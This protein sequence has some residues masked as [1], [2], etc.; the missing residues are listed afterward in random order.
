MPRVQLPI[1]YIDNVST[2][3]HGAVSRPY[4]I[5][6]IPEP[7]ETDVP[8]TTAI[9]I[10]VV[11]TSTNGLRP[12]T[13]V[14][15]TTV[16]EGT[17]AAFTQ[18]IGFDSTYTTSVFVTSSSPGA[19]NIDTHKI[20]L[21]RTTPFLSNEIVTVNVQATSADFKALNTTY[22][23][24][25]VDL[26]TPTIVNAYTSGLTTLIV[27]FSEPIDM[28]G[29]SRSV[30][31]VR[32]LSGRVSFTAPDFIEVGDG[33]FTADSVNDYIC[34]TGASNAINNVYR[35][36]EAL[37]SS[38]EIVTYETD[39]ASEE[40]SLDV[41]AWVGPFK[42]EPVMDTELLFPAFTP[43]IVAAEMIDAQTVKLT[44]EQELTPKHAYRIVATNVN[45]AAFIPNTTHGTSYVFTTEPL[46]FV[47]NR[48]FRLWENFI[49]A[50][51]KRQDTSGD[52]QRFV[53]CFDEVTQLLLNDIDNLQFLQDVDLMPEAALDVA[54]ANLANPYT[55]VTNTL[56]KRKTI[57]SLVKEYKDGGVDRGITDAVKFFL[58]LDVTI[59]SF[60]LLDGWILGVSSLDVDAILGTS[61]SFLRYSFEIVSNTVLTQQQQTIITE[62]AN[63]IKPGHTHFIRFVMP[64]I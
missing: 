32:P 61:E 9:E 44:L 37:V 40:A 48:N 56:T 57:A 38:Q 53:R 26:T 31:R 12:S 54:L 63:I 25:V 11:D 46:P 58:G 39:V 4:L 16:E 17:V 5:S 10:V 36:I 15:V 14:T 29:G 18:G 1:V 47:V 62:I 3:A 59:E 33:N 42:I 22:T 52:N 2:L 27:Q 30:T 13:V 50:I 8:T 21:I 35:Q 23:F 64:T 7:S 19:S 45:D 60:N 28:T 41:V 20:Q 43:C 55:F 34:V 49:P 24:Q 51:N 6:R